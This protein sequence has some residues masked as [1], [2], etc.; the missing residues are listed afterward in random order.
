[1]QKGE[2]VSARIRLPEKP[3][4]SFFSFFFLLF[5]IRKIS[6]HIKTMKMGM[7]TALKS[8]YNISAITLGPWEAL[9]NLLHLANL[10]P[11]ATGHRE[12]IQIGHGTWPRGPSA[13]EQVFS[14]ASVTLTSDIFSE[15][16]NSA[17]QWQLWEKEV[18]R[19]TDIRSD[20]Q[21]WCRGLSVE[22]QQLY[23]LSLF[24]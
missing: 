13:K 1:M 4:R 7:A 12:G 19:K 17:L 9:P 24:K 6:H 16:P 2:E 3:Q 15:T 5:I 10:S 14:Q 20:P 21:T 11:G 22:Y 8:F 23:P 18:W